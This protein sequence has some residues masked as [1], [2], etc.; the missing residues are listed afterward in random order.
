[1]IKLLPARKLRSLW[2]VYHS[3]LQLTCCGL[4]TAFK[5]LC[6]CNQYLHPCKQQSETHALLRFFKFHKN[7]GI[8]A[9]HGIIFFFC[10]FNIYFA[11]S[12]ASAAGFKDESKAPRGC[13]D[14][15][16]KFQFKTL[17]LLPPAVGEVQSMYFIYNISDNRI[18]LFQ[19]RRDDSSQTMYLNHIINGRQW[20]VFSTSEP[21]VQFICTVPEANNLYGMIVDCAKYL[22][23][24]EFTKVRYGL[25]NRGNYWLYNHN[26]RN[27]AIN[28]VLHYG[29]IPVED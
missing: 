7:E 9:K 13:H 14:T 26:T 27:G 20:A 28:A 4:S 25:N 16:Y 17:K 24:C 23:V 21:Q 11:S 19:T 15:G 18:N 2:S 1:M 8:Q 5:R 3:F 12:L 29:I 6:N 22:K 10:I